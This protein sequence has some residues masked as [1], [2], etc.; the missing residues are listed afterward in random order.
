MGWSIEYPGIKCQWQGIPPGIEYPWHQSTPTLNIPRN[1]IPLGIDY[2]SIE[3]PQYLIPLV[4]FDSQGYSISWE[5]S[6]LKGIQYWG[7]LVLGFL[8]YGDNQFQGVLAGWGFQ[9]SCQTAKSKGHLTTDS[10]SRVKHLPHTGLH[11]AFL[12]TI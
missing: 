12:S 1:R 8:I 9:C 3:Y 2:P 7:V 10:S 4:V 11:H 6:V 5:D